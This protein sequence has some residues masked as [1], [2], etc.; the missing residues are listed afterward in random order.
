VPV[1]PLVTIDGPSG[2]PY[3]YGLFSA[4][5]VV[6]VADVH[7]LHS[8]VEWDTLCTGRAAYTAADAC[9]SHDLGDLSRGIPQAQ[10]T[11]LRAYTG[12]RCDT[13]GAGQLLDR[14]RA[15]FA[16]A[17]QATVEYAAWTG[18][19]GNHPRLADPSTEDLGSGAAVPLTVGVGLLEDFLAARHGTTGLLWAHRR[20]A[21]FL[22]ERNLLAADGPRRVAPA[23]TPLALVH[24]DG[25]GPDGAPPA[26]GRAW[27]YATGPVLVRRGPI[28]LP[29]LADVLDRDVNDVFAVAQRSYLVGWGCATAGVLVQL[30]PL[31]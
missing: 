24:T 21:G 12:V 18:T 3:R 11:P 27:L 2:V 6:D 1:T 16:V 10:A 23:G 4:A 20:V 26:A 30:D 13:V 22:A 9:A 29:G 28:Q 8:G 31:T 25:R 14:A 7:E 19:P 5:A 15:L 17:E